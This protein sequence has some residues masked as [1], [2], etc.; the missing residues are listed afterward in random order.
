VSQHRALMDQ[1]GFDIISESDHVLGADGGR[2]WV[3]PDEAITPG[4]TEAMRERFT[5][6]FRSMSLRDLSTL[7]VAVMC[8]KR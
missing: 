6:E 7:S 1:Y 5:G 4:V 2:H 3:G 8:R